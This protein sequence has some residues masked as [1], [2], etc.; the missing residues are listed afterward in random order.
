M[1][2]LER[3]TIRPW[4][5]VARELFGE[6]NPLGK[7]VRTAAMRFRVIGIME[8]KGVILGFDFDNLVFIASAYGARVI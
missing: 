6:I 7:L 1:T 8:R 2:W 3:R 5:A 4:D